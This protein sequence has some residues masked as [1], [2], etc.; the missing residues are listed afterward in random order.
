M[1]NL[2]L[3]H[4]SVGLAFMIL[5]D[6]YCDN[7]GR[8]DLLQISRHALGLKKQYARFGGLSTATAVYWLSA[9]L[10]GQE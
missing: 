5:R 2:G 4:V 1:K 3:G 10:Y 9:I 8:E 7:F 6:A